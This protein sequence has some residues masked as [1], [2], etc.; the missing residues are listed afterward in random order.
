[1]RSVLQYGAESV[2]SANS[3][4]VVVTPLDVFPPAPPKNI[5]AI[6]VPAT[7]DSPARIELSWSIGS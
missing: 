6:A 5:V 7:G 1:V 4:P 2:E 3:N